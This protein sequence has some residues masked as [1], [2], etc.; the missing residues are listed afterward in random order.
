MKSIFFI[1]FLFIFTSLNSQ[2]NPNDQE[3]FSWLIADNVNLR[4]S[5]INGKILTNLP[6]AS[7]LKVMGS[8]D[9]PNENWAEVVYID[10]DKEITGYLLEEFIAEKARFDK[11]TK[12]VFLFKTIGM[13]KNKWGDI[14]PEIQIRVAKNNKELDRTSIVGEHKNG[15]YIKAMNGRGLGNVQNII[16]VDFPQECCACPTGMH[17]LLWNGKKIIKAF[18][19]H[20]GSDAPYFGSSALIFPEDNGGFY[21]AIIKVSYSGY[22]GDDLEEIIEEV[23]TTFY[24]WDSKAE[25]LNVIFPHPEQKK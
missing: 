23:N 13:K 11:N 15:F 2:Y 22:H 1:S 16:T 21:N 4:L 18:I 12:N 17:Y 24:S 8:A 19:L 5:P 14:R 20:D 7:K 9:A 10:G 3:T 25:K 6:I